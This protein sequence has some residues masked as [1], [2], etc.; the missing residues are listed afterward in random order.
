MTIKIAALR[1]ERG[2]EQLPVRLCS[3]HRSRALE[4]GRRRRRMVLPDAMPDYML[5]FS[6]AVNTWDGPRS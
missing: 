5:G 4:A 6:F 3:R 1:F 2:L